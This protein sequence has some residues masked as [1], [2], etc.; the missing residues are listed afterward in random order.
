MAADCSEADLGTEVSTELLRVNVRRDVLAAALVILGALLPWNIH[1]GLGISGSAGGVVAL[2]VVATVLSLLAV[3]LNHTGGQR[4]SA[5]AVDL[6]RR[7]RLRWVLNVPYVALVTGFLGYAVVQSIATG[8]STAV[9][10]G[11]GPGAWIGLAGALLAAQPV[12]AEASTDDTERS[13]ARACRIIG[14]VALVLALVAV[15]GN[16]Y[17]RTR[18]VIPNIGD[19]DTGVQNTFVALAALCYAVVPLLPVVLSV[20]W[21]MSS[22]A[23]GRLATTLLAAATSV[24]GV[25]VWVL[26]V[27]RDLDAFHGIAQTTSTVAVGFEGYLAWAAA[28]ALVGTAV[29]LA[30]TSEGGSPLWR[31]AARK[32]LLLIAVW[33]GGTAVQ[34]IADLMLSAVLDLPDPPYIGATLMSFDLATGLLAMWL[35]VNTSRRAAVPRLLVTVL[36]GVL[37]ALALCR[38]V[39]GV[40]LV[41][42]VPPLDPAAITDVYGNTLNQQVTS[43]FDV[44][45]CILGFALLVIALAASTGAGRKPARPQSVSATP[46]AQEAAA[47]PAAPAASDVRIVRPDPEPQAQPDRVAEV[48]AQSTQRF[49]AGT[50]YGGSSTSSAPSAEQ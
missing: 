24:A 48:L 49:A 2:L 46:P 25:L 27:G 10:P 41:P 50:T 35:Y 17:W 23:A 47:A 6:T 42:R 5:D 34:R 14:L 15:A 1:F 4:L 39:L 44:A 45:L 43:T 22:N 11:L 3:A 21:I 18:F 36:Y 20:R 13:T 7:N 12:V 40:A 16:L 33:C 31:A 9:P 38:V 32:G 19:A 8:G 28:A 30:A 26:P 29:V 37:T